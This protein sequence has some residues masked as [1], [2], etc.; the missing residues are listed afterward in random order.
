MKVL[1]VGVMVGRFDPTK[2][3]A[4]ERNSIEP[5][6]ISRLEADPNTID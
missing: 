1:A 5:E 2:A 3:L 4:V 6:A